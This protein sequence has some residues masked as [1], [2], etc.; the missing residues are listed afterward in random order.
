ML[1]LASQYIPNMKLLNQ[2]FVIV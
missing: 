2:N 1:R